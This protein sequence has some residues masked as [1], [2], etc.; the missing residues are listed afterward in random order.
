MIYR[1]EYDK[2]TKAITISIILLL[3][4][5]DAFIT[6]IS[7]KENFI[8]LAIVITILFFV[9]LF[10]PYIYSP[11]EY[12]LAENGIVIKRIAKDILIPYEKINDVKSIDMNLKAIRLWASGGLYG[13]FGLFRFPKIGKVWAYLKRGKNVLLID[14]D[15]K[16][17]ISPENV[18]LFLMELK[19]KIKK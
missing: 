19:S 12:E 2:L 7:I 5:L 14:A 11:K 17:A 4:F 9:I 1:A 10:I 3:I 13:Y 16:Y 6:Y 18:E 8:S 15:K